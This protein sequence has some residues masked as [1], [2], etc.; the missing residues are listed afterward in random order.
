MLKYE[1][2]ALTDIGNVR[3]NNEDN[4][5]CNGIYK[6]DVSM[7]VYIFDEKGDAGK[8]SVFAVF[9]GMGGADCG[10]TASL[11]AAENLEK[12]FEEIT[13]KER[14]F[15]G[16][17]AI[18][19]MNAALCIEMEKKQAN[20]G[21][22]AVVLSIQAGFA[23]VA[24]VGDSRAYLYRSSSL[25]QLSI[26]H[27]ERGSL[28]RMRKELGLM[29][30]EEDSIPEMKDV[31]TQHLGVSEEDFLLEPYISGMSSLYAGDIYLLCSDG[32]SGMVSDKNIQ[33]VLG[34]PCNI[35]QKAQ[36]LRE[37]A[38]KAGGRDNITLLLLSCFS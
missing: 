18:L 12:Y 23:Q 2:Y 9:D 24:N 37:M 27:T 16:E 10:E 25:E 28:Q 1:A 6:K 33:E 15:S 26:D 31:L 3:T 7:P 36:Q 5:F 34:S 22:T 4:F 20:M 14:I 30:E 8:L 11:T 38:L 29:Q 35:M 21:S 32:L 19:Y 13:A 17:E